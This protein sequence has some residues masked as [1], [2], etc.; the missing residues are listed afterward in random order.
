MKKLLVPRKGV[1][2]R[3]PETRVHL[4]AEGAVRMVTSY[5]NRRIA[6]GDLEARD[7][8]VENKKSA[9]GNSKSKSKG[10]E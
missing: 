10:D 9:K 5:Y 4:P 2:V 8:P 7:I 1:L 3:D 6:D